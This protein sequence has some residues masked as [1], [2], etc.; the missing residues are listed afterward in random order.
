MPLSAGVPLLF[1]QTLGMKGRGVVS[2]LQLGGPGRGSRLSNRLWGLIVKLEVDQAVGLFP[3][4]KYPCEVEQPG[5]ACVVR[6][7]TGALCGL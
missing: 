4:T 6:V 1:P 7:E 3:H 5:G 2:G